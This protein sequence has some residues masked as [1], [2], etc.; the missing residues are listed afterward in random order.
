MV[1]GSREYERYVGCSFLIKD[2]GILC[3]SF[4]PLI[5]DINQIGI[6]IMALFVTFYMVTNLSAFTM[7]FQSFYRG[8]KHI[9][10]TH[11]GPTALK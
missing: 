9:M 6:R 2:I 1:Q 3:E 7:L 11:P 10:V 4:V 5:R 8:L